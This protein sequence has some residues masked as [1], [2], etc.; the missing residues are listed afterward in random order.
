MHHTLS[1]MACL[2][3]L[4][5]F[6]AL[7]GCQS[8]SATNPNMTTATPT[9][10]SNTNSNAA[11]TAS[12][13][14]VPATGAST[15]PEQVV[16]SK[17]LQSSNQST[18]ATEFKLQGKIGV[19]TPQQSGSAFFTWQQQ[20]EE[21]DIQLS[22]ILGVGKTQ[23]TGQPGQVS[24]NSA[25]TG[26]ITAETPEELL[27][28]A[29]G[30]QAPITYLVSWVQAR[31][32]TADAQFQQDDQQRISVLDEAG[33]N[34]QFSYNGQHPLPNRLILK[35]SLEAGQENRITMVIQNR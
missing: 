20:Q 5:L 33:W 21:F 30:W 3:S 7:T 18:V 23:I 4:I 9:F 19:K 14:N 16:V 27:F 35:Q 13:E 8:M 24:L 2:S 34:I 11:A 10:E 12:R 28:R 31:P 29:T 15:A 25:K 32:V 22:G 26:L 6:S 17:D 1:Q